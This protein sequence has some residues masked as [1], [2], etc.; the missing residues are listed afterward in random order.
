MCHA[1]RG[2]LDVAL[3]TLQHAV[4]L[5]AKNPLYRNNLALVLVDAGRPEDAFQQ[6]VAAHGEAVAHYNLG[7]IQLERNMRDQASAHFQRALALNPQLDVARQMLDSM[8]QVPQQAASGRGAGLPV[9][10][11]T[12]APSVNPSLTRLPRAAGTAEF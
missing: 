5:D 3:G 11:P 12:S 8:R 9:A 10:G 4:L 2:N 1:R 6:L 7:F